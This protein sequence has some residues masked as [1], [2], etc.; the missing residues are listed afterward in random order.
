[1]NF[2]NIE[3]LVGLLDEFSLSELTVERDDFKLMARKAYT[4]CT[5]SQPLAANLVEV[6][7][8]EM[9]SEFENS[10]EMVSNELSPPAAIRAALVGLFRHNEPPVGY[11]ARVDIG[12]IVGSIESLK[13]LND[14]RAETAGQIIDVLAEEGAPVE[15][16]QALFRLIAD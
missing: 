7:D 12:D 3:S 11:G 9:L 8:N 14:V 16:G 2:E 4:V 10:A 13:V 6:D 5:P 15:Y 1:M